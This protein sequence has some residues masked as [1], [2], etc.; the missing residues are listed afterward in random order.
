[1]KELETKVRFEDD[2][3]NTFEMILL[4]EFTHNKKKYAVLMEEDLCENESCGD[5]CHCG[6]KN[7]GILEVKKDKDG[8]DIFVTIEDDK[9]FEEVV[10]KAEEALF[11]D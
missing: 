7:M 8:N 9:L 1:M 2:K 10:S 3:G 5:D 6:D 11:E 4:K